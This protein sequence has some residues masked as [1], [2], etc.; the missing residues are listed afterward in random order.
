MRG[1][2]FPRG[3]RLLGR[4]PILAQTVQVCGCVGIELR[5]RNVLGA[6][7]EV[8]VGAIDHVDRRAHVAGELEDREPGGE[9]P[10]G[11]RVAEV[12]DAA[13]REARH[14]SSV[15]DSDAVSLDALGI[16]VLLSQWTLPAWS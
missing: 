15:I 14:R 8:T 10:G 13:S 4:G 9:R 1:F 7:S 3:G 2:R 5:A 12:V 16:F 11:E 6:A